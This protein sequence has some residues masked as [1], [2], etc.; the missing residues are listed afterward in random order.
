MAYIRKI[1]ENKIIIT[2]ETSNKNANLAIFVSA[3]KCTTERGRTLFYSEIEDGY[4]LPSISYK[5]QEGLFPSPPKGKRSI[6]IKVKK[7]TLY[8]YIV[9]DAHRAI[10]RNSKGYTIIGDFATAKWMTRPPGSRK[11]ELY[12]FGNIEGQ[13][14]FNYNSLPAA[15]LDR[16]AFSSERNLRNFNLIEHMKKTV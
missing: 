14:V 13:S 3:Y 16:E 1:D 8:V 4:D 2:D 11:S 6:E 9:S 12:D 7:I 15:G 10:F 5:N